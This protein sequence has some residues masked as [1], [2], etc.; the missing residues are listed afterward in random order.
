MIIR[1]VKGRHDK[2][3]LLGIQNECLCEILTQIILN[4]T[5]AEPNWNTL[6]TN[7]P[8]IVLNFIKTHK[9]ITLGTNC[10]QLSYYLKSLIAILNN[11]NYK[12]YIFPNKTLFLEILNNLQLNPNNIIMFHIMVYKIPLNSPLRIKTKLTTYYIC[13]Q[14]RPFTTNQHKIDLFFKPNLN[15]KNI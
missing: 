11:I 2:L 1:K 5:L 13:I 6:N 7:N 10:I 12:K 15:G 14:S 4:H 3:P 9:E 8:L